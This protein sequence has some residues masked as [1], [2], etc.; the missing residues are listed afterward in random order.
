MKG[1]IGKI[2]FK[3]LK[4]LLIFNFILSKLKNISANEIRYPCVKC[5]NKMFHHKDIVMIHP[6]KK[7]FFKKYLYWYTYGETYVPYET[8]LERMIGS[9]S[10]S[11]NIYG[12]TDDNSNSY[13][14]IVMDK[15]RMNHGYSG[16]G[17]RNI[18]LKEEPSV[19]ATRFFELL[20]DFDELLWDGC[21]T[22]NKLLAIA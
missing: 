6:F 1:C 8:L 11:S 13:T 2:I 12:F 14:S 15:I 7:G 22:T 17:S 10:S 3:R 9:T 21:T 16:E 5:K 4:V 18:I 20:K 19:D